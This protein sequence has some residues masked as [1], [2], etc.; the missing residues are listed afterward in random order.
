VLDA[1][2]VLQMEQP[3]AMRAI[4]IRRRLVE[5]GVWVRPFGRLVYL[6][7]SSVIDNDELQRL[8]AATV[9]LLAK[10]AS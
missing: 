3:V 9:A 5:S 4:H 1:I 10:Q 2:G 6:M 7:R 8:T